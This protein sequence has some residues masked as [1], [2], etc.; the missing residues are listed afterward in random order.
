MNSNTTFALLIAALATWIFAPA[1][2]AA[3][4]FLSMSPS[5]LVWTIGVFA[6][7]SVVFETPRDWILDR[8]Q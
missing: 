4:A 8:F 7:L 1:L 5:T 2:A 3:I 6:A